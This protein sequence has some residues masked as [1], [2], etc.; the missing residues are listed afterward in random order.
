MGM[1][2][3]KRMQNGVEQ[4]VREAIVMDNKQKK[5]LFLRAGARLVLAEQDIDVASVE[6]AAVELCKGEEVLK[7]E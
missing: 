1:S 6:E 7:I 3:V 2:D 5:M 4:T